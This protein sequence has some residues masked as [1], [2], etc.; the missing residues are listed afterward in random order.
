MQPQRARTD[1]PPALR[2]LRLG[3]EIE[4][5]LPQWDTS[6]VL[7]DGALKDAEGARLAGVRGDGAEVE[8]AAALGAQA[9]EGALPGDVGEEV[10]G[11]GARGKD[12]VFVVGAFGY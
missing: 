7:V 8:A 3:G 5:G 2:G 10:G 9:V 6:R 1:P 11:L 12:Q 4:I